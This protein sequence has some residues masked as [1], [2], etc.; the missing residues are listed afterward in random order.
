LLL[1][2]VRW[3]VLKIATLR[4][5]PD[6]TRLRA[7]AIRLLTAM[8]AHVQEQEWH[9][10][11][12]LVTWP[13]YR[14]LTRE[15]ALSKGSIGPARQELIA[16]GLIAPL[17]GAHKR[18]GCDPVAAYLIHTKIIRSPEQQQMAEHRAKVRRKHRRYKEDQRAM[19]AAHADARRA[20]AA[21]DGAE[22][23]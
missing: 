4:R 12:R 22:V 15:T 6:G 3:E 17:A 7:S 2:V 20:P 23:A 21:A 10:R 9:D 1:D 16:F 14:E 11:R 5:A 8:L 19:G 18:G 13:C